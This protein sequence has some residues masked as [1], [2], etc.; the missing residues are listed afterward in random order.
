MDC[1]LGGWWPLY[2]LGES[3][4][5]FSG[6][7]GGSI[8]HLISIEQAPRIPKRTL[9]L[10]PPTPTPG[11]MLAQMLNY[12]K[13]E[14]KNCTRAAILTR[15]LD[16]SL[17]TNPLTD[18]AHSCFFCLQ[19]HPAS[20]SLLP[21]SPGHHSLALGLSGEYRME[22][23]HVIMWFC[24]LQEALQCWLLFSGSRYTLAA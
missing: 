10:V 15:S 21:L 13:R 16:L 20:S 3:Q 4:L 11:P 17:L 6:P 24:C 19:W 8:T 18:P 7:W 22:Q 14:N 1:Y 12:R 2:C 5:K 23:W 9:P